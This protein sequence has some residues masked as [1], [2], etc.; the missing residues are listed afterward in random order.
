MGFVDNM[1]EQKIP[2]IGDKYKYVYTGT[3]L[4]IN[5]IRLAWHITDWCNYSCPYCIQSVNHHYAKEPKETQEYVE[6]MA[7]LLRPKL[8]KQK[9]TLTLYGGEISTYYN[10]RRIVEI[11]FKDNESDATVTLL[12]NLSA[13]LE[14]YKDFM[15][16]SDKNLHIRIIPSYQWSNVDEFIN[17]CVFIRKFL[18]NAFQCS[19][20]VFDKTT[21]E[22]LKEVAEKFRKANIPIRF[23]HGRMPK[24]NNT[25]YTLQEGVSDF[26][27]NWNKNVFEK[28]TCH[29]TYADGTEKP[30]FA[31]SD[32]LKEVADYQGFNGAYFKD[33]M[34]FTGLNLTPNGNLRA[35]SCPDR[36]K[37]Y[38]ANIFEDKDFTLKPYKSKCEGKGFCNLCNSILIWNG[39]Y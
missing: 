14:K 15:N 8:H 30:C 3:E 29:I 16:C 12:T 19:C 38:I 6:S 7:K 18:G 1:N 26:I 35:G 37:L 13:P 10:L 23:T 21:L 36:S 20:V 27:I 22:H 2:F 28:I 25:F 34:C 17:K 32:I 11:L 9:V 33:M 39:K 5:R 24:S 31:R 4:N